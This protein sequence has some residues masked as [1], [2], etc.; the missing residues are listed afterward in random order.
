MIALRTLQA[1][2]AVAGIAISG[3]TAA[4]STDLTDAYGRQLVDGTRLKPLA[5]PSHAPHPAANPLTWTLAP[6]ISHPSGAWPDGVEIGDVTGDG[7]PDAVVATTFYF[8]PQTDHHVFVFPQD[9]T[10]ALQSPTLTPYLQSP[11]QTG[12]ALAQLDGANGLD[13]IVG[14]GGLSVLLSGEDGQLGPAALYPGPAAVTLDLLD[15]NN[16]DVLDIASVTWGNGGNVHFSQGDGTFVS[17]PWNATVS[18][19]N[20]SAVGDLDGDGD[21]D[22]AI[23]SG[24]GSAPNLRLYRNNGDGTLDDEIAAFVA[25]CGVWRS[26]GVGI[27]DLNS[28]GHA[29]VVVAAGGNS[30]GSCLLVYYGEGNDAYSPPVNITS[31]DIPETLRVADMNG[32]GRDDVV[33]VHG[34]WNSLGVYLQSADGNL[35]P[36]A[37]FPIPYASHYGAEGLAIADVNSDA[38]LDVAIADYNHGLVILYGQECIPPSFQDG[39]ELRE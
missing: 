30:P 37:L 27:G 3:A 11:N 34:G 39:F 18:G 24:Q 14:G 13:V 15:L 38:C 10:G 9:E 23:A 5:H 7:I 35:Q 22:I 33:V 8:S 12:L 32:D 28:D 31:Y 36:E 25:T 4:Q 6:Y 29:D 17:Y 1:A 26:R 16:D 19:Y 2:I 21:T 20:S